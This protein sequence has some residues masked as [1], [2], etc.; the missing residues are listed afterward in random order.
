MALHNELG[1]YGEE[2][3]RIYLLEKEF[4]ILFMNW[5]YSYYEI[6]IIAN[7]NNILHIIEIKTRRNLKYGFPEEGVDKKKLENLLNAGEAFIYQFPEWQKVQY[8]ILSIYIEKCKLPE[9]LFIEDV[10]I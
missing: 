1:K 4:Q 9:Y 8:D 7:K 5:K 6:D 2:L 3:A 10:Y